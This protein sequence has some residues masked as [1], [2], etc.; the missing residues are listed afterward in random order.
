MEVGT[1]GK[2]LHPP[3]WALWAAYGIWKLHL[4]GRENADTTGGRIYPH[5]S[6]GVLHRWH[7]AC[8]LGKVG[9]V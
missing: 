9:P 2:V 1:L 4:R 8:V 3:P 5:D 6:P 7:R